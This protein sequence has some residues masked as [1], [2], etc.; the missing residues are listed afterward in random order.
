[1]QAHRAGRYHYGPIPRESDSNRRAPHLQCSARTNSAISRGLFISVF[2]F[3]TNAWR[4]RN[5]SNARRVVWKHCRHLD[6]D[7]KR[8]RGS[9][10]AE[11]LPHYCVGYSTS[12]CGVI[13][14]IRVLRA[15]DHSEMR[16]IGAFRI[17]KRCPDKLFHV[18]DTTTTTHVTSNLSRLHDDVRR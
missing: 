7:P 15:R 8:K 17:G 11:P 2:N 16:R 5:E 13:P 3:L 6:S 10:F 14:R 12:A 1:M 18:C 4:A 9:A